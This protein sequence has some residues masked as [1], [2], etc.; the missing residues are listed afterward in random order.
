MKFSLK[1]LQVFDQIA[2]HQSVTVAA[3]ELNMS[4]SAVSMALAQLE[5]MLGK[6][7]FLRQGRQM[8]L[9]DWG[10]WLRPQVLQ[11]LNQCRT[12]ELGMDQMDIVSGQLELGASQTPAEFL[13]PTL[14]SDLDQAYPKLEVTLGVENTEHIIDGLLDYRYDLGIIEG[15]CDDE[16]LTQAPLCEDELVIIAGIHHPLSGRA[17]VSLSELE[18]ARWVLRERG[19]GTREIFNHSIHKHL[20]KL[21]VHREFDQV[22]VI[23]AMLRQGEYLSCL[24][25][26]VVRNAVEAGELS[27]LSCPQL[28]MTRDFRFIWR[29]EDTS[30]ALKQL[31]MNAAQEVSLPR[32]Q[33]SSE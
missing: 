18:K 23:L 11:I 22:E 5:T 26:R 30:H 32:L 8:S 2:E 21:R 16:R 15:Y 17:S 29:K 9:S 13:V 25:Q 3:R 27:I 10:S 1:Q 6:P 19:A 28:S 12:I 24:S 4:Q 31:V 7:L 14:M 20:K 33:G